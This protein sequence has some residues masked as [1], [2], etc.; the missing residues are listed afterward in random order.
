MKADVQNHGVLVL[1]IACKTRNSV[2]VP[3]SGHLLQRIRF[4]RTS[5]L[6]NS[7]IVSRFGTSVDS[8]NRL[9]ETLDPC[10]Q[11]ELL[12]SQGNEA[13]FVKF[14]CGIFMRTSFSIAQATDRRTHLIPPPNI[15]PFL[16]EQLFNYRPRVQQ[17]YILQHQ[18]Y[19]DVYTRFMLDN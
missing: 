1:Q 14:F 19:Y 3:D 13:E 7:T 8:L 17:Y 5:Y 16:R 2:C 4:P 6:E 9:L 11:D 15:P 18:Q 10:L 12:Q